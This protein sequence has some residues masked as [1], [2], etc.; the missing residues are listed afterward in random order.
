MVD[1]ASRDGS[2]AM[3]R[4]EFPHAHAMTAR[5]TAGMRMPTISRCARLLGLSGQR[6]G[7]KVTMTS[8]RSRRVCR[9]VCAD[10][11]LWLSP[12]HRRPA[13]CTRCPGELH[14]GPASGLPGA[15]PELLLGDG[16]LDCCLPAILPNA[17]GRLLP[18]DRPDLPV[19]AQPTL[20]PL[21]Y[22]LPRPRSQTEVDSVVGACMLV[23]GAVVREVGLLD[24]AYFMYGED[25]DWACGS[26]SMAGRLCTC[27]A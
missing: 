18:H 1:N 15:W 12:R 14:G 11:V 9:P 3:V 17:R 25:L 7:D 23:R 24:E 22:E 2:A 21:Q 6:H 5:A 27:R 20:R 10:Y 19:P 4:A 16:S 26:S 13:W 8:A